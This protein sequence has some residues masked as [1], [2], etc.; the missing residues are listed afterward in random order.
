[1]SSG[2]A[3]YE[4]EHRA[5]VWRIRRFNGGTECHLNAEADLVHTTRK[6]TWTRPPISMDFQVIM[7]T[8]SGLNVRS[9]KVYEKSSYETFKWVRYVTRGGQYQ[10]RI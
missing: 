7:F 8:A 6:K 5:I 10:I 3:Q 1:V 9:L 4:P 2:R